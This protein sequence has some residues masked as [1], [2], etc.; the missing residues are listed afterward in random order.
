VSAAVQIFA[1]TG[2]PLGVLP[3]GTYNLLGRDLGMST[4][5][6]EAVRQLASGRAQI[7]LGKVGRRYFHTL[8]GL[9]FFSRVA[10]QRRRS[11][12]PFRAR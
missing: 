3:F 10:R 11:A 12:N 2:T 8:S 7:D 1:G 9:G 5:Y 6:E 4:E